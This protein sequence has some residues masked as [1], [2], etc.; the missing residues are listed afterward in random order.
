MPQNLI[1]LSEG[2]QLTAYFRSEREKII[3][4]LYEGQNILPICESFDIA[5]FQELLALTDCTGV[6]IYGG[7]NEKKEICFV[8]CGIDRN[9]KDIFLPPG[10]GI[11]EERVI[12]NGARCPLD[13]PAPSML[14]S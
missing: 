2:A 4:P 9:N 12:E 7:M 3:N 6:R 13:C 11:P 14:N 1:P 5:A 10:E 8:I